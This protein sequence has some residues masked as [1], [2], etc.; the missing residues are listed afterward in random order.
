VLLME[1]GKIRPGSV[2][3]YT[4]PISLSPDPAL[5]RPHAGTFERRP[6]ERIA[7]IEEGRGPQPNL[8]EIEAIARGGIPISELFKIVEDNNPEEWAPHEAAGRTE[9]TASR[10][11]QRVTE[12]ALTGGAY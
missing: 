8:E 9:L 6:A 1:R 2:C 12:V 11:V 5:H 7:E 10:R 3:T 4:L